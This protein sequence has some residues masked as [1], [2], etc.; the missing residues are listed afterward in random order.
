MAPGLAIPSNRAAILTPSPIRSPS[1]L[2]NHVAKMDADPELDPPSSAQPG[3]A[4]D[5]ARSAPR[6]HS[7]PHPPRCELDQN[8]VAS[9]LDDAAAIACDGGIDQFATQRADARDGASSSAPTSRLYP[10]TSAA[11]I[12]ASLRVSAM[13]APQPQARLAQGRFKTDPFNY[14]A[15]SAGGP[16][17]QAPF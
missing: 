5:H 7:A 9:R 3:I 4:F 14:R 12:A 13:T 2:N 15:M 8:A 6:W 1:R 17:R 11:N 16:S 10:T